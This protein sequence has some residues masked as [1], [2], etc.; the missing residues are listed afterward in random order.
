MG[1]V[2]CIVLIRE[3]ENKEDFE[4][5]ENIDDVVDKIGDYYDPIDID[6]DCI[7]RDSPKFLEELKEVY[8]SILSDIDFYDELSKK[9]KKENRKQSEYLHK[10]KKYASL[11]G[12]PHYGS[13]CITNDTYGEYC[14]EE[15]KDMIDH[16]DKMEDFKGMIVL[17]I[18]C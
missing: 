16:P 8:K 1:R 12:V 10:Y 5:A 3:I 14:P 13:S 2:K 11:A 17:S 15:I 4:S 18:H 9:D 7:Y 6:R